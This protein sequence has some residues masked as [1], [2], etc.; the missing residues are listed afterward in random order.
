M[1]HLREQYWAVEV[2]KMAK[3][4]RLDY[5]CN[6]EY[7]E[8]IFYKD[9]DDTDFPEEIVEIKIIDLPPGTWVIV[10]TSKEATR[11]HAYEIVEWFQLAEQTGYRDYSFSDDLR[12]PFTDPLVSLNSLLNSK[13]CD[14][15]KNYRIL[16][17]TA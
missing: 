11:D 5:T 9:S 2:P 16:K 10:C 1:I 7:C 15:N 14:L 6:G 17:K 13:G 3:Y 8:L 12:Y 4:H